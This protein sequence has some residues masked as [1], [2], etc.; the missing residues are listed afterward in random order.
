MREKYPFHTIEPKWQD[1]WSNEKC[2]V[3]DS[4]KLDSKFYC[5]TMFPYPSG[6]LHMGH[7][8]NYTL[9]D[10]I[11]RYQMLQ[12]HTPLTPMGW[13]SFGLPAENAAIRTG[14]HPH[15]FTDQNI[16]KMTEQ[17]QRAGWGYDWDRELAT[18]HPD[19]YRWTQWFFL[20]F[21]KQELA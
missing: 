7:V 12:G 20:Q 15:E 13:D 1:R 21:Y 14:T 5:L 6:V 9:G 11:T 16:T 3:A 2:F 4:D 18:S 10:V 19:Y 8:I 17:M